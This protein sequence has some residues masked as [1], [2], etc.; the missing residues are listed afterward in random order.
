VNILNLQ[1]EIKRREYIVKDKSLR[2]SYRARIAV[3]LAE[4]KLWYKTW[5][6]KHEASP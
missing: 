1:V 5:Q 2:W 6:L 3:D 4:L